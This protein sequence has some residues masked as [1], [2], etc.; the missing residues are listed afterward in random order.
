VRASL[1]AMPPRVWAPP[2]KRVRKPLPPLRY[3][4]GEEQVYAQELLGIAKECEKIVS[5]QLITRLPS[6]MRRG[7]RA[8][9]P[10]RGRRT[11]SFDDDLRRLLTQLGRLLRVPVGQAR[12]IAMR[13]LDSV[14]IQ[15]ANEFAASYADVL[16]L[17]PLIGKEKWFLDA[18]GVSLNE[19]VRLI[20][21][22]PEQ[23][24]A[25]V[26]A[27]V[28]NAVLSGKRAEDLATEIVARFS[29]TESRAALIAQDQVGRWFGSLQKLRQQDAG[30]ESYEWST[31]SDERVRASHRAREGK[32]Y[33]W[34]QPPSGGNHPGLEIR[35]RCVA[36][37]NVPHW[38]G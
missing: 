5:E 36:I 38:E 6:L 18:F 3:P 10:A 29:V 25:S 27:L 15:H 1:A 28:T 24:H 13:M 12:R 23:L 19:N 17:N 31:S 14:N 7:E 9:T 8:L 30:I 35:C 11:D 22:I 33:R 26:E 4:Y 32:T 20:Q 37:P 21:S 2:K 16:S 34:D